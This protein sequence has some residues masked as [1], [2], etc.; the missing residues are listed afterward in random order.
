MP[1]LARN[2][3]FVPQGYLGAFTDT[4]TRD[5]QL[6]AFDLTNQKSFRTRPRNVAAKKD[7]NRFEMEGQ[8]PDFL[9]KG[10]GELENKAIAV[11]RGMGQT[12]QR[13]KDEDLVYVINLISLL[14]VRNP[15]ARRSVTRAR[16]QTAKNIGEMLISDKKVWENHLRKAR[17]ADHIA[18][19]GV[20]FERMKEFVEGGRYTIKVTTEALIRTELSAFDQVLQSVGSRRWSLIDAVSHAPDFI[21]CDHPITLVSNDPEA[22]GPVGVGL[23]QTEIVFPIN[24]RQALL[25]VFEDSPG[26]E[27]SAS[28]HSVAAINSRVIRHADRQ[29]YSR[30]SKMSF[31][32]GGQ[33]VTHE[34]R[35]SRHVP[36]T[37][38]RRPL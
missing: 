33:V 6:Y 31:I 11:I 4:G 25:G 37:S 18:G 36:G 35:P 22:R 9:E 24:P 2:H 26:P 15:R 21:T 34:F 27:V 17:E 13:A 30:E 5:G 10:F 20:S 32:R 16:Q 23:K 12:K 38:L 19:P 14:I 8:P 7:F 28:P 3:H 29:L 1:T